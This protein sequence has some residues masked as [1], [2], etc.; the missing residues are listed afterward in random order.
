MRNAFY[1]GRQDIKQQGKWLTN[2]VEQFA[3]ENG[4]RE[5]E[6]KSF[7]TRTWVEGASYTLGSA[8]NAVA[9]IYT[10]GAAGA[11]TTT[12]TFTDPLGTTYTT[13]TK[14]KTSP[15]PFNRLPKVPTLRLNFRK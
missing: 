11:P 8:F 14:G 3:I 5:E 2:R 10:R 7:N 6:I 12:K 9:T 4:L 15:K 13:T 1:Q